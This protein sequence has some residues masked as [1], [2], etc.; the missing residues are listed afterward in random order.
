MIFAIKMKEGEGAVALQDI[1]AILPDVNSP[2][3]CSVIY[4]SL[5]PT[6]L[7]VDGNAEDLCVRWYVALNELLASQYEDEVDE[8][9]EDDDDSEEELD[10]EEDAPNGNVA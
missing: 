2:D 9:D 8:G 1:G 5:F 7:G 3:R 6:G 4:T 10:E